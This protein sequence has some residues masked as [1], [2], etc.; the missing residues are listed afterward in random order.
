MTEN[1]YTA[2]S[3]IKSNGLTLAS[4]IPLDTNQVHRVVAQ[5]EREGYVT[6]VDVPKKVLSERAEAR[7]KGRPPTY[8]LKHTKEGTKALREYEKQAA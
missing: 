1:Q 5:L 3:F 7:A 6:K 4:D 8:C 2:L